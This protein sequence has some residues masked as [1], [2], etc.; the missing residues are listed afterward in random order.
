MKQSILLIILLFSLIALYA[1]YRMISFQADQPYEFTFKEPV[2]PPE[3]IEE[4]K[5]LS[6]TVLTPAEMKKRDAALNVIQNAIDAYQGYEEK[7]PAQSS[8]SLSILNG[9]FLSG[10]L[11]T[12]FLGMSDPVTGRRQYGSLKF[13]ADAVTIAEA[14]K[15]NISCIHDLSGTE[16]L[17]GSE[18]DNI[19][20]CDSLNRGI[21]SGDRLILGGPGDDKITDTFGNRIVNGGSGNDTI[22][23]GPGRSI[24]IL[25]DGWGQDQVTVDCNGSSVNAIQIP[26]DFPGLWDYKYTNFIVISPRIE[27][28]DIVW[29]GLTLKTK[30]GDDTLSVN[31]NCFTIVPAP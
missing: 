2:L 1:G 19:I 15:K 4:E 12:H 8:S 6:Q 13:T 17:I 23:L 26:S 7:L 5:K 25:E 27:S 11:P 20:E 16:T 9:Y 31:E 18:D 22:A 28:T 10:E 29:D 30:S 24:I 21:S 3:L 14:T